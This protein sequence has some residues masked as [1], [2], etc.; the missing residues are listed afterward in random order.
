MK[1]LNQET[2]PL[3]SETDVV[4]ARTRVRHWSQQAKFSLL[5]QTKFV[6]AASEVARNTLIHGGGGEVH[7][8]LVDGTGRTG[9]RLVFEDHGP[10]I[11]DL[12]QALT[13]GYT[14]GRGMGMGLPG[15]K[16]L[17]NEF[18]VQSKPGEGT[19]VSLVRWK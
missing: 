10:G 1:I 6:T 12:Q 16:R 15:A 4:A 9:V 2:L 13:D 5:E 8:E 3:R 19:R 14:S 7:I 11:A 17:V 18:D